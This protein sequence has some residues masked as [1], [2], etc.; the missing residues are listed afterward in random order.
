MNRPAPWSAARTLARF[1]PQAGLAAVLLAG[2]LLRLHALQAASGRPLDPDAETVYAI[3]SSM[4]H[5]YDTDFREPLW[6]WLV[7]LFRLAFGDSHEAMRYYSVAV[8][9]LLLYVAYRFVRDYTGHVG[10]ALLTAS[11][12]A[13]SE[14]LAAFSVRGLRDE[15]HALCLTGVAYFAYV[16]ALRPR[17]RAAGL[18]V[19]TALTGLTVVSTIVPAWG[20]AAWSVWTRRLTWRGAGLVML[21]TIAA[22]LPHLVNNVRV[23]GEPFWF[24][25]TA[26]TAFFRNY[27]YLAV[28]K[29]GCAGCPSPEE[30]ARDSNSG[31]PVTLRAYVF[32]MHSLREVVSRVARGYSLLFVE[33][34]DLHHYYIGSRHV[35]AD[36]AYYLGLAGLVLGPYRELLLVPV[37]AINLLAFVI[38]IGSDPRLVLHTVAIGALA[39]ALPVWA[40]LRLARSLCEAPAAVAGSLARRR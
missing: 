26:N 4:R 39:V 17:I 1:W 18:A 32:G 40:G 30:Y 37:L 23:H 3:V 28:K 21:A 9:V 25:N 13:V 14:S 24:T 19:A 15:L 6:P 29:T 38:P 36:L 22:I 5:P 33:P 2:L 31:R 10:L 34:S 8:S 20:L 11:W 12:L 7:K 35:L 27:E 16:P